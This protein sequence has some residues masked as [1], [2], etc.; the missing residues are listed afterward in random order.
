MTISGR[1]KRNVGVRVSVGI[2]YRA[3]LGRLID[4]LKYAV[5]TSLVGSIKYPV[6]LRLYSKAPGSRKTARYW[7][8]TDSRLRP[9]AR[10]ALRTWRPPLEAIRDRK[11]WVRARLMV[12]G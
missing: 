2:S 11:P 6:E 9:L 3:V 12:L 4:S 10:R 7:L 5:G 1:I 8:Q